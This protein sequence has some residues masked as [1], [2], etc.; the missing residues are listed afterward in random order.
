MAA[1]TRYAAAISALSVLSAV[2]G[3]PF[4]GYPSCIP[5]TTTVY[6]TITVPEGWKQS[7]VAAPVKSDTPKAAADPIKPEY[8]PDSSWSVPGVTWP[9]FSPENPNPNGPYY[10]PHNWI[11]EPITWPGR[12]TKGQERAPPKPS[13]RPLP[14][15]GYDADKYDA[16]HWCLKGSN[17]KPG[18]SQQD[19]NG[20]SKWGLI[21]CPHLPPY[22]GADSGSV[23][24]SASFTGSHSF[25]Y[26]VSSKVGYSSSGPVGPTVTSSS[27]VPF[28]SH[29]F[30]GNG[31][32]SEYP[33]SRISS[34]ATTSSY[35]SSITSSIFSDKCVADDTSAACGA[36]PDTGVTRHFDFDIAYGTHA[37]D[38]V[39]R[40]GILI[41]GQFP[42][43][44]IEA[45]WGDYIEVTVTN[46]L[47]L[48]SGNHGEPTS[49]HWHGLLQSETPFFDGVPS[50]QQCPIIPGKSLTYKFRADQF[51]TSW[52]HS[53]YSAQYAGGAFGPIVIHG[54]ATA[55]YD[56]D[57][58]PITLSDLYHK[59][60]FTMLTEV[61]NNTIPLSNNALINGK[62]NYPCS[63]TTL[64]CTPNAGVSKFKF[65]PGKKYRL[66]LINTSSEVSYL[67]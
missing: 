13:G 25:S 47:P 39:T 23:K 31:S 21:D 22:V 37:P 3:T 62:N 56:E 14:V 12:P 44:L 6:T 15:G 1:T 53:H 41:N 48:T 59:D 45:N 5:T 7:A 66:R 42:G 65:T 58:G 29:S 24:P 36:M 38:G 35:I 52:Y 30:S 19:T 17:L 63:D 11:P 57:I 67:F 55:C 64:E 50:V 10:N 18:L 8:T 40:N 27:G 4:P 16:P 49:L 61:M 46:S 26:G 28:P 32:K 60:Y 9:T 20:N 34:S 51:G 43:P 2:S 33:S 54:P